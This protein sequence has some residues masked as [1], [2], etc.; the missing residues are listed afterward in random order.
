LQDK[1][2]HS[3]VFIWL[4]PATPLSHNRRAY[5]SWRERVEHR[6]L[7]RAPTSWNTREKKFKLYKILETGNY[8]YI[9]KGSP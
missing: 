5:P 7:S 6:A 3:P 8:D 9:E 4:N 1:C 2:T